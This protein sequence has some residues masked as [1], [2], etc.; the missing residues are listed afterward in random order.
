[1]FAKDVEYHSFSAKISNIAV[2]LMFKVATI[3]VGEILPSVPGAAKETSI[4]LK[5]S[6]VK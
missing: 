6:V 2:L 3:A 1:M 4:L 5:Q